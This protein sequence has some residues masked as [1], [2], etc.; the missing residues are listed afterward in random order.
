MRAAQPAVSSRDTIEM[1]KKL[2]MWLFNV[3]MCF[4]RRTEKKWHNQINRF[5]RPDLS[6]IRR[7]NSEFCSKVDCQGLK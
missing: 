7:H 3:R 5:F 2:R 6:K 4:E 1:Q